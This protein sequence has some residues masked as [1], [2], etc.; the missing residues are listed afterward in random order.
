[1]TANETTPENVTAPENETVNTEPNYTNPLSFTRVLGTPD[2]SESNI[3]CPISHP[4]YNG[5]ECLDCFDPEPLFDLESGQCTTCPEGQYFIS[6]LHVC[7][8]TPEEE[9]NE[10]APVGNATQPENVSAPENVTAN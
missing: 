4:F 1:M 3:A 8:G 5:T 9:A 7:S 10:T 2:E 6:D